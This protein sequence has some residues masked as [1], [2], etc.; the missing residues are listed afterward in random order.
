MIEGTEW[1]EKKSLRSEI[2]GRKQ[3]YSARELNAQSLEIQAKIES[4]EVFKR[5]ESVLLYC[6][7]PDEVQTSQMLTAWMATKTCFLP[8]VDGNR[9]L[10]REHRAGNELKPGYMGILE[11]AGN[12]V[13]DPDSIDLIIVPGIAFDAAGNRLGRGK[14]YYDRLLARTKTVSIGVCFDF[15]LVESVP[16]C[17]HDVPVRYV[18]TPTAVYC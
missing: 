1:T 12:I 8:Q 4:L 17:E 16:V 7:L 13:A 5:S 3:S 14:G 9:M 10:I 18:V 15:Q 2:A 6:S 11:P